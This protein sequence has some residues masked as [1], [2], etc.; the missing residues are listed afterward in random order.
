MRSRGRIMKLGVLKGTYPLLDVSAKAGF[1]C[2]GVIHNGL[3]LE[4]W[5]FSD[6]KYMYILIYGLR[7]LND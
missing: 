1:L 2:S 5:W 6:K 7:E 3:V 4:G